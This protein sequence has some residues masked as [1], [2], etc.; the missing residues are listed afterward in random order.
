MIPVLLKCCSRVPISLHYTFHHSKSKAYSNVSAYL[1]ILPKKHRLWCPEWN[2]ERQKRATILVHLKAEQFI[3]K[4]KNIKQERR[5]KVHQFHKLVFAA[6]WSLK[7]FQ[8]RENDLLSLEILPFNLTP[9]VTVFHFFILPYPVNIEPLC[10]NQ[11][12]QQ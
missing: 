1:S 6:I 7:R 2:R 10:W 4:N 12:S 3:I 11:R 8:H 9:L 5:K